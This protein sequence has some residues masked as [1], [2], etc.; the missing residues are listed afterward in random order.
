MHS[1]I[2]DTTLNEWNNRILA[3]RTRG[4]Q[5]R[6][7]VAKLLS[8]EAVTIRIPRTTLGS[9][10]EVESYVQELREQ[11]LKQIAESPVII[12]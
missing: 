2:N 4:T 6:E 1:L 12:A 11:L 8:P 7:Q 9:K 5:T 3:T 10:E